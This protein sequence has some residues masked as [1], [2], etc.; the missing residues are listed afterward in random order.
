MVSMVRAAEMSGELDTIMEQIADQLEASMEFRRT[1]LTSM[2][3]PVL[4]IVMTVVAIAVL[5]LVVIPKF[6]PLLAGAGQEMPWATQIVVDVTK[7][8]QNYAKCL[9]LGLASLLAVVPL[10]QKTAEGGYLLDWLRM[11]LPIIGTIIKCGMVVNFSRNLAILFASGVSI[12]DALK[13][14]QGTLRNHVGAQ[15]V[16]T[17]I[18]EIEQGGSMAAPLLKADH[19]FPPMVGEMLATSEETGEVEKVLLL[20]ARIHQKMLEN[21]VSRMNAMIEPLLIVLL[22]SI[23]GFVFYALISGML[24]AYGV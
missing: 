10:L 22:G 16:E 12:S 19:V 7:W 15:V 4:V 23:V 3:Y 17:M 20:T 1:M 11:K 2:I 9:F 6:M 8:V 18:S 5:T 13:T 14:V 21:A 24:A